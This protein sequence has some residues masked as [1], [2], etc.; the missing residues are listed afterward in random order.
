MPLWE[1]EANKEGGRVTFRMALQYAN[2]FWENLL[3]ALIGDQFPVESKVNG[4]YLNVSP[5]KQVIQVWTGCKEP[6]AVEA[7][8]KSL[9]EILK[10]PD[11]IIIS[12]QDFSFQQDSKGDKKPD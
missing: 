12:F 4:V 7:L 10:L 9:R 3:F 8:I 2:Y 11:T 6:Q 5:T 1:D